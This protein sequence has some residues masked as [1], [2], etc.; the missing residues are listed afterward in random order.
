M[1]R[2]DSLEK[3]LMLGKTE[4][5]RRRRWRVKCLDGITDL[6][7][8]NQNKLQDTAETEEPGVLQSIE[9]QSRT[10]LRGW[11]TT[12]NSSL[13]LAPPRSDF[14]HCRHPAPVLWAP[15][16]PQCIWSWVHLPSKTPLLQSPPHP[17]QT[18]SMSFYSSLTSV[19][20]IIFSLTMCSQIT[21]L[22]NEHIL[23]CVHI[24]ATE[25]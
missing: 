12:M 21:L 13:S 11:T 3:T 1:R 9:L 22:T 18:P 8:M 23:S 14:P 19:M 24:I 4:D 17:S 10:W 15:T 2:A 5:R 16:F 7:D 25:F 20:N 6:M